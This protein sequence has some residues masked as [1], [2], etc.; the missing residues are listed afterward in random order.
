LDNYITSYHI[1]IVCIF[2]YLKDCLLN[3]TNS[4]DCVFGQHFIELPV[5]IIDH[6]MHVQKTAN[7]G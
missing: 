2:A 7:A 1:G 4:L 3:L 6:L 5:A